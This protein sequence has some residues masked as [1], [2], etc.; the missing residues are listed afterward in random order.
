MGLYQTKK[1][2]YNKENNHQ[3]ET[4]TYRL[5]VNYLSD[6]GLISRI[7]KE[8]KH[9]NRKKEKKK[10][11]KT[12]KGS[13]QTFLK[14][15]HINGPKSMEKC[16]RSLI[17]RQMQIKTTMRYHL[18]PLRMAMIRKT[19]NIKCWQGCKGKRIPLYCWWEY[20]LVQPL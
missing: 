13:E 16:S 6:R 7:Y 5:G 18:T 8:L 15:R 14:R 20:K 3:S 11:K 19:K 1:L 4:V 12:G 10:K 9:L 2:L 17:I